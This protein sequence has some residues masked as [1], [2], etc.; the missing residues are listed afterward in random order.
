MT[1]KQQFIR[2]L[3]ENHIYEE[4]LSACHTTATHLNIDKQQFINMRLNESLNP[5][6][7]VEKE[8]F[9]TN[10]YEKW[11]EIIMQK[12]RDMF[13]SFMKQNCAYER[14]KHNLKDKEVQTYITS[15]HPST[16][17]NCAFSWRQSQEKFNYWDKLDK[18]WQNYRLSKSNYQ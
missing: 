12:Q 4:F 11:N 14:F 2:F 5:F 6:S 1:H 3:K 17:I 9:T 10:S 7:G 15:H 16:F 13:I 18:K 8:Q